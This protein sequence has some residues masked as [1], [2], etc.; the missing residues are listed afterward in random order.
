MKKT[1][2]ELMDIIKEFDVSKMFEDFKFNQ[3]EITNTYCDGMVWVGDN[4]KLQIQLVI[5]MLGDTIT[6]GVHHIDEEGTVQQEVIDELTP[7]VDYFIDF[8]RSLGYDYSKEIIHYIT[9]LLMET[10]NE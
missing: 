3:Y 5:G 1:D 8:V 7:K 6:L 2:K 4:P 10:L 9:L